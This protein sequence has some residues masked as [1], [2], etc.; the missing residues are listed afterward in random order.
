MASPKVIYVKLVPSSTVRTLHFLQQTRA[1]MPTFLIVD[2]FSN[3]EKLTMV[4]LDKDP[5]PP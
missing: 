4:D 1:P 2:N 3:F 5:P